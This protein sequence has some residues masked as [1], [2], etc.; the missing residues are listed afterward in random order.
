[1]S[2]MV[3]GVYDSESEAIDRIQG[4]VDQGYNAKDI[5]ILAKDDGTMDR[6]ADKTNVSEEHLDEDVNEAAYGTIAGFLS[7]IG[8]AIAVPGL[9]V[10]GIG[11]LLAAGPFAS[12]FSED[13]EEDLKELLM[14]L[15]LSERTAERYVQK[16]EQGSV[17]V[18]LE[19]DAVK[20]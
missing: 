17:M 12:M 9:G 14:S 11:P 1:M 13:S 3:I 4:L 18:F 5:S 8:G 19:K 15:D 20:L 2:K 7:G 10:P 16:V 6:V